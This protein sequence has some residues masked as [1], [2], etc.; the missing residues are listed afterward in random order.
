M[1]KILLPSVTRVRVRRSGVRTLKEETALHLERFRNKILEENKNDP[2]FWNARVKN[3]ME[4]IDDLNW[5]I[6]K[7]PL[8][9]LW[10]PEYASRFKDIYKTCH[11]LGIDVDLTGD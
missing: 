2:L 5:D 7:H 10:P 4:D 1:T 11:R 9:K 8:G 6:D 3:L